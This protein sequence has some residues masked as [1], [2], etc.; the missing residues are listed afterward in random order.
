MNEIDRIQNIEEL[1]PR[2]LDGETSEAENRV[3]EEWLHEDE[4]HS[5]LLNQ[6]NTIYLASDTLKLQKNL[7]VEFALHQVKE[8]MSNKQISWWQ[9]IQRATAV[10][11]IPLLLSATYLYIYDTQDLS[12]TSMLVART[13]PGMTA[14]I[15]LPDS[16]IVYLNSE[17]ILRY[18]SH[19]DET[20]REVELLGEGYFD[21]TTNPKNPFIINTGGKTQIEVYGTEFNVE[22]YTDDD[23]I[24]T[25]LV[26]GSV[27][28]VYESN[29]GN[30]WRVK[31]HPNQKILYNKKSKN[32]TL[33]STS[34]ISETAWKDNKLVF[35]NTPMNE[36]LH[37][38]GKRFN[39][40][41]IIKNKSVLSN[42]FTGVFTNQRLEAILE[43]FKI[44]SKISWQ[45]IE[46]TDISAEKRVIEI[47]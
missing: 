41:F 31:L 46:N 1:L 5:R 16:T 38:L 11:F 47:I 33:K 21:V 8:R 44:S 39:V 24:S 32:V 35:E 23:L 10:L 19:F 45:F 12:Y 6:M 36:I 4:T 34:C 9:W 30:S 18:P 26:N 40:K 14:S 42:S 13:N 27:S 17:S 2:Y 28:F 22:A 43:F 15:I 7:D 20:K 25:T 29:T 3:I 37:M